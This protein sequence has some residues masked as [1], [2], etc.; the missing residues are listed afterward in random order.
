MVDLASGS[1]SLEVF[2]PQ[3]VWWALI[4]MGELHK[5]KKVLLHTVYLPS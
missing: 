4:F 2:I 1:Y 3:E 5:H